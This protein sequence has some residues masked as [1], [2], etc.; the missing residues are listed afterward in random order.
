MK[1]FLRLLKSDG[2][3][4]AIEYSV[5]AAVMGLALMGIMPLLA[6]AIYDKFSSIAD[7]I[8]TGN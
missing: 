5:I 4:T 6:S 8:S 7:H 3:A 1:Q 2:G